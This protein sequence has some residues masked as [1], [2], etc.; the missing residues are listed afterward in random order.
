VKKKIM[1]NNK[2]KNSEKGIAIIFALGVISLLLVLA[3]G[4]VSTAILEK[5]TGENLSDQ[6]VARMVA[7]SGLQRV[8]AA[9]K[10]YSSDPTIDFSNVYSQCVSYPL[11]SAEATEDLTTLLPTESDGIEYYSLSDYES[12]TDTPTWQ[13]LPFDHSTDIPIVARFAYL[14]INNYR[15]KLDLSA[16]VDSGENAEANSV[17]AISENYPVSEATSIDSNGASVIGRP[18]RNVSELFL[19]TLPLIG[20]TDTAAKLSSDNIAGSPMGT[21]PYGTR[22]PDLSTAFINLDITAD[23][24]KTSFFNLFTTD[25]PAIPEAF[26]IDSNT[27]AARV[28]AELYHRFNLTRSDW[29]NLT[30]DSLK[31]D[32]VIFSDTY[33]ENNVTS[34]PWLK[35][36]A[37]TGGYPNS[38]IARNQIMANLID[39]NDSDTIATT[40]NPDS[41]TY[42]G[43]EK[44]PYINEV[45]TEIQG[46]VISSGGVDV[47]WSNN[48]MVINGNMI[49]LTGGHTN[50]KLTIN[51]S[52]I[53]A[54]D[55][56]T[57]VTSVDNNTSV[58]TS[59]TTL[60]SAPTMPHSLSWYENNADHTYNGDIKL[61]KSGSKKIKEVNSG[62]KFSD[63]C[64]IYVTNGKIEINQDNFNKQV[65]LV[66]EN[67]EIILNGNNITL[68]PASNASNLL[69]WANN[70]SNGKV[71]INGDSFTGSGIIKSGNEL[72]LDGDGISVTSANLWSDHK[73]SINNNNIAATGAGGGGTYTCNMYLK[74]IEVELVNMYN[75]GPMDCIANVTAEGTYNWIVDSVD[76][77]ISFSKT[78]PISILTDSL[79]YFTGSSGDAA[80]SDISPSDARAGSSTSIEDFQFTGLRVKL[81]DA[82]NNLLD[83]SFIEPSTTYIDV[84][85]GVTVS[86][87]L[88]INPGSMPSSHPFIM[89][90]VADGELTRDDIVSWNVTDTYSGNATEIKIKPK[91]PGQGGTSI[92]INDS[93]VNLDTNTYYTFTGNM[94]VNLHNTHSNTG[95]TYGQATGNWWIDISGSDITIDPGFGGSTVGGDDGPPTVSSDGTLDTLFIDYEIADPRQ[96]LNLTDWGG[97][98]RFDTVDTGT[99]GSV[100]TKFI[101]NPGGDADSEPNA[102]EPWEISTAYIRNAPMLSP[103]ELGFLH[104]GANWQTINLKKYNSDDYVGIGGGSAYSDGDANILDQIKMTPD[105]ETYGKISINSNIEEVLKVLFQKINVGSDISNSNG[106]GTLSGTEIDATAAALLA[107]EI[108]DTNS[109]RGGRL[110]VTRAQMLRQTNGVSGLHNNSLGLSQTTD[111]TQEEI[112]GKSINLTTAFHQNLYTVI[113]VAQSIKDVGIRGSATTVNVNGVACQTGRYDIGGDEILATQKILAIVKRNPATGKF[114][115]MEYEYIDD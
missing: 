115:I 21:L 80:D 6:T 100:N 10:Y 33:S 83:Y 18:G 75:T 81:T 98:T 94:T 63:N 76:S 13:Y 22:W 56:F 72:K 38:S 44:C 41:P 112:I 1:K 87:D 67:S 57:Y 86:G 51:G 59:Q 111:A 79:N 78:I 102:T 50:N 73:L 60:Q 85:G 82:S 90:T 36:W 89:Q 52:N 77:E 93:E 11:E 43:L 103:W 23:T 95:K 39:Y 68:Q 16:S 54:T 27:D 70:S 58:T 106:P 84:T 105:T 92:T 64:I 12:S 37:D 42:V 65:T 35:N 40:D 96:N 71:T 66:C 14:V 109:T 8:I 61:K 26:W 45:Q 49:S 113:V 9:M 91:T 4:F 88:N 104:R 17:N 20:Q 25:N 7:Q 62:D 108:L 5:K 107:Q 48:E 3:V 47:L 46:E 29:D 19:A 34:I 69:I 28:E 24:A 31:L 74:N 53:T 110:F 32:P 15:G 55:S 2:I 30:I 114:Y 101:P 99:I 97:I